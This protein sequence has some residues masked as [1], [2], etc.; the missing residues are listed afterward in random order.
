MYG[1][2]SFDHHPLGSIGLGDNSPFHAG[3]TAAADPAYVQA[4]LSSSAM[5][6]EINATDTNWGEH[7]SPASAASN[8]AEWDRA[9]DGVAQS[10]I[11]G[12]PQI[13]M[14]GETLQTAPAIPVP[15]PAAV[16]LLGAV[17]M[18]WLGFCKHRRHSAQDDYG[19]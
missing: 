10:Y 7:L 17:L 18:A 14:P 1:D 8:P 2:S 15:L 11:V 6:A 16:W 4:S 12:Q 3:W 19:A 9:L 5:H 13:L